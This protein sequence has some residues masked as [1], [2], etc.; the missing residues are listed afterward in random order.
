MQIHSNQNVW[1]WILILV[2]F[3][4]VSLILW[5]TYIFFQNFK[6]EERKKMEIWSFAQSEFSESIDL[7]TPV[8]EITSY[9]LENN[10]TTPMMT[11]DTEGNI[12]NIR[13]ID[14]SGIRNPQAYLEKLK[15][16]FMNE[17]APIEIQFQDTNFGQIIYGNS[18]TTMVSN[19]GTYII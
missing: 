10:T 15:V 14:T 12:T 6:A 2:S 1:R 16:R 9:V 4:I 17:N 18:D 3:I 5:N 8:S 11:V 19:A 13:N 7:N